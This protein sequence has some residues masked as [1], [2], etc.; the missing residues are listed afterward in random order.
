MSEFLR[1]I[2]RLIK[3]KI[4]TRYIPGKGRHSLGVS[5]KGSED[6]MEPKFFLQHANPQLYLQDA[7][8]LD[9]DEAGLYLVDVAQMDDD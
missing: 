6:P 4:I 9:E 3:K 7:V 8:Q 2:F 1:F 5:A